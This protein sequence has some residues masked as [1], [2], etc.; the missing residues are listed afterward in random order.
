MQE[1]V[2][3]RGRLTASA[4][5]GRICFELIYQQCSLDN[6]QRLPFILA[7]Y[8]GRAQQL[9]EEKTI[10]YL[11]IGEMQPERDHKLKATERSYVDDALG[12]KGRE[13]RADH[14]FEFEMRVE[15]GR[16]NALVL[17]YIGDDKDR[18]FDILVDG[19]KIATV[20][21]PGGKTGKFYDHTYQIPG[22]ITLSK[23]PFRFAL[24]FY[25]ELFRSECVFYESPLIPMS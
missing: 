7:K 16:D 17:T 22:S 21:W 13:A 11:R 8:R 1:M 20:E 18:K 10:D 15:K 12:R 2:Q 9:L 19:K 25:Y 6:V 4:L 3:L 23:D 24:C 5:Y 14:Y